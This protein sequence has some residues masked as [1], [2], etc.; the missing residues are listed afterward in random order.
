MSAVYE[1]HVTGLI[2]PVVESALP[3]LTP[4]PAPK[5]SVLTGTAGEPRVVQELLD[6]L[7]DHGL[8]ADHIVIA[9]RTRWRETFPSARGQ[10]PSTGNDEKTDWDRR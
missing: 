3:E 7:T 5:H 8:V 9:A 4:H 1:F 2:G 10:G 6:K